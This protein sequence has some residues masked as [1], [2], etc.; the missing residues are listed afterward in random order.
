M[1]LS[2]EIG[3]DAV[4]LDVYELLRLGGTQSAK[5]IRAAYQLRD[6]YGTKETASVLEEA[7]QVDEWRDIFQRRF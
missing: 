4:L 7:A 2:T 5:D 6:K 3:P 1:D